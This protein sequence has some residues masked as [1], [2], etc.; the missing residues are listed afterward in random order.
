MKR[1]PIWPYY[2]DEK[3]NI[4]NLKGRKIKPIQ[5]HTGYSVFTARN[6]GKVKQYRIHRFVWETLKGDIPKGMVINHKNGNKKDN[7]L[8]NLE[9]VTPKQNAQHRFDVLGHTGKKGELSHLAKLSE[10]QVRELLA[11]LHFSN[12]ELGE[13]YKIHP[14][15]VSLIRHGKRWK[16]LAR[17]EGAT[18]IPKGSKLQ[19]SGS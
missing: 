9:V 13:K 1:H 5:H 16:H 12:K 2:V 19:A 11:N 6:K 18:T 14:N 3:G 10:S 7:R 15:Y 8:E 4:Y 17:Q